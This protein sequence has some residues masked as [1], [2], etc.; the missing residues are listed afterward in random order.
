MDAKTRG[1]KMTLVK[2]NPFEAKVTSVDKKK[3]EWRYHVNLEKK[4]CGC[5]QWQISGLPCPHFL[6]SITSLRG[7]TTEID[8]YVH[9]YYSI[10]RFN[11]MYAEN[12]LPLRES[13]SGGL[14]I[15]VLCSTPHRREEHQ[16]G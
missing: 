12:A 15:E 7:S 11:A 4:T 3:R 13:T 16:E 9:E 1:L 10:A 6:F 8:Q 2:R 14:L 5:R